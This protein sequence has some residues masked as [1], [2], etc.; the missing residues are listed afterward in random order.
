MRLVTFT[1]SELTAL[2]KVCTPVVRPGSVE[3]LALFGHDMEGLSLSTTVMVKVHDFLFREI[4]LTV[5]ITSVGPA[6]NLVTL[7]PKYIYQ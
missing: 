5:M 4:S 1:L 2:S 7:E 6:G 3:M